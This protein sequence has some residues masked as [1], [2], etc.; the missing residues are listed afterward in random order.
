M[1]FFNDP[2]KNL[3]LK[4]V[5]DSNLSTYLNLAQ[6]YEAEFSPITKKNPNLTGLYELD[7]T[8]GG[9]VKA[10]ILQNSANA[11]GFAAAS[12]PE[13]GTR[14]L[15]EFYIVPTMRG[16]KIGTYLARQVFSFYPGKWTVKQLKQATH[17]TSF[18]HQ[19]LSELGIPY[20]ETILLDEYWGNVVMQT[21][22]IMPQ[23]YP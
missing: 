16:K 18:W 6:A 5:C 12:V 1:T 8:I 11:I 3:C 23:S 10:Y 17:A 21:F 2:V 9:E 13:E 7:T 22:Q 19:A 14:D 20:E 15:C 4:A